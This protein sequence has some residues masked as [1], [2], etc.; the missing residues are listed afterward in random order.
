MEAVRHLISH[1]KVHEEQ[2]IALARQR[3]K[4]IASLAGLS[5][6][7]QTRLITALSEILRNALQFA[8]GVA[9]DLGILD[10]PGRQFVHVTVSDRGPGIANLDDILKGNNLPVNGK[11][12]GIANARKVIDL[13]SINSEPGKGTRVVLGKELPQKGLRVNAEMA[14]EW[15]KKLSRPTVT[16]LMQELQ[17]QNQQ[18]LSAL[19]ETQQ[20]RSELERQLIT[21]Q[22]LN[23]ELDQTNKGIMALYKELDESRTELLK[24]TELLEKQQKQLEAATKHKSE[25][26]ASMSH[27]IR[28]PMNGVLGMAEILM[29]SG[30]TAKQRNYVESMC[31]AGRSLLSVINDVLD[32]SK[33][34]AGKLTIEVSEF[35]PVRL[36]EDVAELLAIQ[37]RQ[38][39]LSLSTFI[40]P[41]I[42]P[43]LRGDQM[44][45]RQILMNLIGNAVKFSEQ[46]SVAVRVTTESRHDR[47]A[48]VKFSVTDTGIGLTDKELAKLFEPFVQGQGKNSRKP[49]GSGLGLSISKRLVELMNGT[50]EVVS[51]KG[52]G[53]TF[54]FTLPLEVPAVAQSGLSS[55]CISSNLRVLVVDDD[56]YARQIMQ[57][58]ISSWRIA[59]DIAG[60]GRQ[61]L[62]KLHEAVMMAK[63]YDLAIIDL[64]MP[65]IDGIQL[66]KAILEDD[67][68]KETRL[69]LITAFDRPG[70][71]EEA[72]N[73]GFSAY[74]TKPIR[75]S[76]LL[77]AIASV[78]YK[79]A[80][81]AELMEMEPT[82]QLLALGENAGARK[83][84]ILVAEDHPINQEVALLQLKGLGFEAHIADNGLQVLQKIKRTHYSLVFMDCQMPEMDGFEATRSI[85][86]LEAQTGRHIPI[87][88]MTAHAIEGSREQCLGAG[89]D[90][91]VSKPIGGGSLRI[92]LDK[93]LP[94]RSAG[95]EAA[96]DAASDALLLCPSASDYQPIDLDLLQDK[97]GK[98]GALRLLSMYLPQLPSDLGLIRSAVGEGDANK[99]VR[100]A[101]ALKGVFASIC[102]EHLR[103][104]CVKLEDAALEENWDN[105]KAIMQ[106]FAQSHSRLEVFIRQTLETVREGECQSHAK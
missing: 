2:D 70:I 21:V 56:P 71:G 22:Q 86:K 48:R 16:D 77:D 33:I 12:R 92:I 9:V 67:Q 25:F 85:R 91:Y 87:I 29:N 38:N 39:S 64:K 8:T 81:P 52:R 42:P 73:L 60:D 68:L 20:Y 37:A 96:G 69:I 72:I 44:R 18:L 51:A 35:E 89:M 106:A 83:E 79:P 46:G 1:F 74:L 4:E 90:D 75:Q 36:V 105:A 11:G 6:Q 101:H 54:S 31:K 88:A 24:K 93:W 97:M 53:S 28:T 63:P 7:D 82:D 41:D 15:S 40:D 80:Q 17:E 104:L 99:L 78:M 58:Y 3:T 50:I 61:A 100:G 14:A 59:N 10:E 49:S 98:A 23:N 95:T 62:A 94:P 19:E 32:F 43:V 57:T 34:E 27:E 103:S 26:L 30:L 55:P 76:Q 84:L 102:A 47:S 13:F 5:L 65:E 45:L 66:G